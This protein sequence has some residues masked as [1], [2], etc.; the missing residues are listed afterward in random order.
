MLW[1]TQNCILL[2]VVGALFGFFLFL[3]WTIACATLPALAK[4]F[5][6]IE[7]VFTRGG[8]AM[9]NSTFFAVM[10]GLVYLCVD[11]VLKAAYVL[12]CFYGESIQ[13]GA[14]L[15][16]EL[17]RL[18]PTSAGLA[19]GIMTAM[20]LC[21]GTAAPRAPDE[22]GA[23]ASSRRVS[24][25]HADKMSALPGFALAAETAPFSSDVSEVSPESAPPLPPL[26]Q[27]TAPTNVAPE[28]LDRAI[29]D[30]LE[31]RKY[32]WRMP[33]EGE[34]EEEQGVI[35]R[36]LDRVSEMLRRWMRAAA[37][38]LERM[39]DKL[40]RRDRGLSIFGGGGLWSLNLL[41]YA[42]LTVVVVAAVIL[43]MR[44][45]YNRRQKSTA[46]LAQAIESIPDIA[47]ETASADQL[48]EDSWTRL[49]REL[50]QRGEF[51]LALRAF[52]F[53][54]LAHLAGRSLIRIARFK[55][56]RDYER[57]LRRRGHSLPGLQT[58]FSENVSVF[59]RSWYGRYEVTDELVN[60]F[61]KNVER[62]KTTA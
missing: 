28:D 4:M 36:F 60:D 59:D 6:G 55:S 45:W 58:I 14:D 48:P 7:S 37:D 18:K 25:A 22:P 1:P 16:A 13:S 33:R 54:S 61:A 46:P 8:V 24:L 3:N 12:R 51:R 44:T 43:L 38:W 26:P 11:P 40:F 50:L 5:L 49:A 19:I 17:R 9:M 15:K 32:S 42:L 41:I 34:I 47:D 35:G 2:L 20:M 53:A 21:T 57:E 29:S 30:T 39:L 56:N 10:L 23:P 31:Q 52:Y 27:P 62:I